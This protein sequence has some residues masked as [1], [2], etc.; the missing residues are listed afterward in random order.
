M[1]KAL[2]TLKL[3]MYAVGPLLLCV[4]MYLYFPLRQTLL[5]IGASRNSWINLDT[6]CTFFYALIFQTIVLVFSQI[7]SKEENAQLRKLIKY[8]GVPLGSMVLVIES[9]Y[10][11]LFSNLSFIHICGFAGIILFQLL[12]SYLSLSQDSK[13]RI[14]ALIIVICEALALLLNYLIPLLFSF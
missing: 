8:F 13:R 1:D 12:V 14:I 3:A 5:S 10:L 9:Y 4:I 11:L 7:A 6:P 2:T